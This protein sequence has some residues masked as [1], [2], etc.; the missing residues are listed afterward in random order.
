L[1]LFLGFL[2]LLS[3]SPAPADPE[4]EKNEEKESFEINRGDNANYDNGCQS[5]QN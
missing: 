2:R 5:E 1:L 3:A 4:R